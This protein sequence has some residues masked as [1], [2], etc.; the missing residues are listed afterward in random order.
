MLYL[1]KPDK[2]HP[3]QT[4]IASYEITQALFPNDPD[5][6]LVISSPRRG[7]VGA[8]L[9]AEVN[10]HY[11]T[12]EWVGRG[13]R[14]WLENLR[15]Q[16]KKR[17]VAYAQLQDRAQ[18]KIRARLARHPVKRSKRHV[19]ILLFVHLETDLNRLQ[20]ELSV[21]GIGLERDVSSVRKEARLAK[22]LSTRRQYFRWSIPIQ[23]FSPI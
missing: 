11:W 1:C 5:R 22:S 17:A 4:E 18:S 8:L 7:H 3:R 6:M 15:R 19:K 21:F 16:D 2:Q 23:L 9:W 12:G 20:F 10:D 14:V 13:K